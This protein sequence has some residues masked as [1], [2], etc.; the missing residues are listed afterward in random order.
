MSQ[1]TPPSLLSRLHSAF[2]SPT[3]SSPNL[4][5]SSSLP[6]SS[7]SSSSPP[8][9]RAGTLAVLPNAPKNHG[10]NPDYPSLDTEAYAA[11]VANSKV[12][13]T[14]LKEVL[15]G[16]SRKKGFA[17]AASPESSGLASSNDDASAARSSSELICVTGPSFPAPKKRRGRKGRRRTSR[18][19]YV[20]GKVIDGKHELYA[21]SIAMM[22]GLRH[23][24]FE[25]ERDEGSEG[26]SPSEGMCARS[27]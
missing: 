1:P 19:S 13:V 26:E 27:R 20:K 4:S 2:T 16:K 6:P 7:P 18:R 23:A 14:K 10:I 22:L 12:K 9:P 21:L 5:R 11:I 3:P 25:Q 17:A 15:T 8:R 24:I